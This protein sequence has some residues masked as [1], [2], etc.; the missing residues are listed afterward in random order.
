MFF[1]E[2][3]FE[4]ITTWAKTEEYI[5][6]HLDVLQ[7]NP[8]FPPDLP[9]AND[10]NISE[11]T[12]RRFMFLPHVYVPLVL[13]ARGYTMKQLWDVLY[14]ALLQRNDVISC[15]P[16]LQWM[17]ATSSGTTLADPVQIGPPATAI[18]LQIPPA[19]ETL[20]L[21]CHEVLH[22]ALPSLAAP[23][24][25]L[26]TA[27]SQMA[28]ALI[29]QTNDS[30]IARDQKIAQDAAPKLPSDRFTVTLPVLMEYLQVGDEA[31]LPPIWHNWSNC[32]KRLEAQ[33]LR[34]TLDAFARSTD[35]FSSALPVV[36]ARLV[37]DLLA[38]NFIG[39]SS[40]DIKTGLHPFI[41]AD[42]NSEHRQ[43]NTEVA[44][45]Y[46]LLNAGE[47]T[48]SL[49]DLEALTAKEVRS[50]PLTYWELEKTL[51]MFGNLIGV[52]L[53]IN[54]PLTIEF[55]AM[56]AL[57]QTSVRED[58][59]AALDYKKYVKPTHI[60][61]SI[62]LTFY[63]WFT[64]RRARLT[65]P[66]PDM[67]GIIQQILLQVYVLPNLPPALYQLAYPRKQPT[68]SN[69]LVPGLVSASSSDASSLS[70]ASTGASSVV[71]RLTTPTTPTLLSATRNTAI[72]GTAITNLHPN[73]TLQTLL[74]PNIKI[75]DLIHNT[76]PPLLDAGGEMCLSFLV[77][78]T[79]WSNCKR[80]AQHRA[81]LN[82]G[83]LTR[84]EQYIQ[85]QKQAY[86]ARR[87]NATASARTPPVPP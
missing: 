61:R 15:A 19:D 28:T 22:K 64:H 83:E 33:V 26:E 72:R 73:V 23:P 48:C 87:A 63:T 52:I 21:H 51:G 4:P 78:N 79:C 41:I 77:R 34:D 9:D 54:H 82:P 84:L 37:Q 68:P 67:K 45:L 13:S 53:G 86:T 56:W 24:A 17:R 16:L 6:Q 74:P 36:T 57:L 12:T 47:A 32:A 65:P 39:M 49:A 29:V 11:V 40:E 8:T 18:P 30:R 66:I 7:H 81:D 25:S 44:R 71:S 59:H 80:A 46:G 85:A 2:N 5:T 55:R 27:L 62:Q 75:K 20:L 69:L 58:L 1:P 50:V 43:T 14:P 38:F 35:A 42:G 60:L 10:P 70:G 31:D 3:A 76:S